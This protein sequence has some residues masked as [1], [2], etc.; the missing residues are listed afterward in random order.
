VISTAP[1]LAAIVILAGPFLA[2][3]RLSYS[4]L[5]RANICSLAGGLISFCS[6]LLN[7]VSQLLL[8]L[9]LLVLLCFLYLIIT[10]NSFVCFR[11]S[12]RC[13]CNGFERG[14]KCIVSAI[15]TKSKSVIVR[16]KIESIVVSTIVIS[17][18]QIE[19]ES[20]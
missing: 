14:L 5:A 2:A 12:Y 7:I 16:S 1:V 10:V 18:R 6:T 9:K 15:T 11:I 8:V 4:D 20:S 13:G 3:E 19:I 17:A